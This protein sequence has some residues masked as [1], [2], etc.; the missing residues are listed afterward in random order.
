MIRM[1]E[2]GKIGFGL[3]SEFIKVEG[4]GAVKDTISNVS[5]PKVG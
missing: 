2:S 5:G 4:V 1:S 3:F